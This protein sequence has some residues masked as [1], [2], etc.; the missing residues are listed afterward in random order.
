MLLRNC[1]LNRVIKGKIEEG[2]EVTERQG[3]RRKHLLDDLK[4]RRSW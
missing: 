1:L 4:Q 2:I 3:E